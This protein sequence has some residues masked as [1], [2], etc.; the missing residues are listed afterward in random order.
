M[1]IYRYSIIIFLMIISIGC[2]STQDKDLEIALCL[3][4]KNRVQLEKVM[5]HYA[6]DSLK[7]EAA[8]F[9]IRNMPGHYS[10]EDTAKINRFYKSLDSLTM[11]LKDSSCQ[12]IQNKIIELYNK[13]RIS[14]LRVIDDVR[15]ISSEFLIDNI[16]NAFS[17]WKNMPWLKRLDFNQFCEY[18]LPYKTAELQELRSWR[19]SY[20]YLY[21]DSIKIMNSCSLFRTSAFQVTE[22]VNNCL[23][24]LYSRDPYDYNIPPL[25]Y[26]PLSRLAIPF[27]T[28]DEYCNA[29]LNIFRA[30]GVPCTIDY[31]PLWGY[32]NRGHSWG[33]ALA[34]NGKYIAFVPI[35]MSPYV[36][37]KINETISKVYRHTYAHN[38][39]LIELN[40]SE[41]Y[42]P[43]A[44]KNI[45]QRDVTELYADT[46][47][48]QLNVNDKNASYAYLCTTSRNEWN[49]VAFSKIRSH[50]ADFKDIGKGCIYLLVTYDCFGK[51]KVHGHPFI[52][53][54]DG[55]YRPVI[56]DNNNL[57]NVTLYRKSPLLEYAW[58][59][60][61]MIN[62]GF[63]EASNDPNFNKSTIVGRVNT[64]ADKAGEINIDQGIGSFRYWRYI[65]QGETAHC[66]IGDISFMSRGATLNAKATPISNCNLNI[67]DR[68]GNINLAFD[69]NPLTSV[70]FS[71][72]GSAW[73]GLDFGKPQAVDMIRYTPRGDGNSIEP[74]DV[75][76]LSYWNNDCWVSID[77]KTANTVS[78][79]FSNVPKNAILY[80]RDC[81]KGTDD[82]IFMIDKNGEQQ[83]W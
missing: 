68:H 38:A 36:Q 32:G 75:Y 51:M 63:F 4:G 54:R 19:N 46:R 61:K 48:I 13:H 39:E 14:E 35:Q 43:P 12:T 74:G 72:A 6:D 8:K 77:K 67:N 52:I 33:A 9:L 71:H 3:A 31:V 59:M 50:K 82:R 49:P 20:R 44:F 62:G 15:I 53:D 1:K 28:C 24:K 76:E 18:I 64:S 5:N 41:T 40:N 55:A 21:D 70:S 11:A 10:Y 27:G 65:Q 80:M 23:K 73:I 2:Q 81:T 45:F 37:H 79:D 29:G 60:A 57:I 58:N 16:D 69:G 78:I 83:W 17:Q 22:V 7:L 56:Q 34:P 30:A 66:Y 42:V 47:D 25:Y 26:R